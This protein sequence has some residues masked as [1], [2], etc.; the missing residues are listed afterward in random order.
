MTTTEIRILELMASKICHDLISPIGAISNGVEF[1]EDMGPESTD[2]ITGLISFSAAQATAKLKVLRLA[3]GLGGA[4]SSILPKDIHLVFGDYIGGEKR[5]TQNWDP[6][7]GIGPDDLP[8]GYSKILLCTLLLATEALPKGGEIS[9]HQDS[10]TTVITAQ[11]ENAGF[12]DGYVDA[13]DQK[14][15]ADNI[16]PKLVHAYLTGLLSKHYGMSVTIEKGDSN[17]IYLRLKPSIVSS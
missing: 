6:Y 17:N 2:E 7:R 11:G 14:I 15:S 4:D 16:E 9:V 1:L 3:Y 10:H 13:F 12:R 8:K 5:I